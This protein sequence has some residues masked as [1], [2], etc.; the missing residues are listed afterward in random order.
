MVSLVKPAK[1]GYKY[2]LGKYILET[3]EIIESKYFS[4][5]EVKNLFNTFF[6]GKK[7]NSR[8]L[9]NLLNELY[10][11]DFVD[12]VKLNKIPYYRFH[13]KKIAEYVDNKE[14]QTRA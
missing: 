7:Y 5:E 4:K 13:V 1:K 10:K 8:V 12:V 11:F 14:R 3:E 9:S 2:L 6:K